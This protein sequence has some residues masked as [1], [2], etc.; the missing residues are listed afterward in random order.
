MLQLQHAPPEIL[1]VLGAHA[2]AAAFGAGAGLAAALHVGSGF[3]GEEGVVVVAPG[4]GV[5]MVV[6]LIHDGKVVD[7]ITNIE[8][9][10]MWML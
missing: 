2:L 8:V 4:K 6:V 1:R 7:I 10:C 5:T 9:N 3:G